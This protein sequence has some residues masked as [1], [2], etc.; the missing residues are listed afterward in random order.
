MR[1]HSPWFGARVYIAVEVPQ[2]S[3]IPALSQGWAPTVY[4]VQQ[5]AEIPQVQFL[6]MVV[7]APVVVQRPVLMVQTVQ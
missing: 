7:D 4:S 2:W 6:G 3:D 1:S 5:K